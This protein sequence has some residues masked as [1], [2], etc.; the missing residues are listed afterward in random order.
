MKYTH[1][2]EDEQYQ[3]CES[4]A[5]NVSQ[6]AIARLMGRSASTIFRDLQ[7]NWGQRGY[8]PRQAQGKAI[9]RRQ[10][11]QN[12]QQIN[13]DVLEKIDARLRLDHSPKQVSQTLRAESLGMVSYERIYQ[14]IYANKFFRR[15]QLD[16]HSTHSLCCALPH[17]SS[18]VRPA[19]ADR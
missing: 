7:R 10:A 6:A 1:F 19:P 2:T 9:A 4:L 15:A 16:T 17:P 18:A 13:D 8:R 12:S 3:I 11:C 5:A 14:G